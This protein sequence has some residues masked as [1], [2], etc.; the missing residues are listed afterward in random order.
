M[1]IL[2]GEFWGT[3]SL[4][5]QIAILFLLIF[6][7]SIVKGVR[8]SKKNLRIHGYLTIL[9]LAIH[10]ILTFF[11]MIPTHFAELEKLGEVSFFSFSIV[12]SYVLFGSLVLI[13]GSR[14]VWSWVSKPLN[15]LAC[16]RMQ[17]MMLP[18]FLVWEIS[19]FIGVLIQLRGLL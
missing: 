5:L 17:K 12:W 11:I 3:I 14:V 4:V 2:L 13:L 16:L 8:T 6:G 1:A 10:T 18:I 9:A 15:D 7:L 19:A